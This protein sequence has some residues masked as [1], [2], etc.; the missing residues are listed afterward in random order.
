MADLHLDLLAHVRIAS[1][2]PVRWEDMTGSDTVRHCAQCNLSVHNLS[3]MTRDDA[4]SLLA[5]RAEGRLCAGFFRRA[6]GTILTRDCPVGLA[7][8]RARVRRTAARVA[9]ALGLVAAGTVAAATSARE[10]M[11]PSPLRLRA[12]QPFAALAHW[13]VP[14]QPPPPPPV[15]GRWLAGEVC[16][17][18][19]PAPTTNTA[20]PPPSGAASNGG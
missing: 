9:A 14:A 1:P 12:L 11:A 15:R 2:C 10:S 17:A 7:A 3:A 16:P 5:S 19:R 18:P 8:V 20:P 13:F 6:D 4:E